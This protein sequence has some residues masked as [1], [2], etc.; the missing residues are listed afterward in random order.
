LP[1]PPRL[2][3][4]QNDTSIGYYALCCKNDLKLHATT[5]RADVTKHTSLHSLN[6]PV[7]IRPAF[8][9]THVVNIIIIVICIASITTAIS[10]GSGRI[11]SIVVIIITTAIITDTV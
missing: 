9:L 11:I 3:L 2:P 6:A 8:Q 7:C 1:P 4:L 10:S 5:Q